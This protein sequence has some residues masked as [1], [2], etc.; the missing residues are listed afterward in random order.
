MLLQLDQ[1]GARFVRGAQ[2][3]L[4]D[5]LQQR[6]A[7]AVQINQGMTASSFAQAGTGDHRL[8]C[9]NLPVSSSRCAR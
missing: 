4:R 2:V 8:L 1:V 7:G 5:D 6:H 3:R 9:T